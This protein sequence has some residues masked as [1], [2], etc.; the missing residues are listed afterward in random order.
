MLRSA[1][2]SRGRNKRLEY[3]FFTMLSIHRDSLDLLFPLSC[4]TINYPYGNPSS[5]PSYDSYMLQEGDNSDKVSKVPKQMR[6]LKCAY[7]SIH[8]YSGIV[9]TGRQLIHTTYSTTYNITIILLYE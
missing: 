6:L 8:K 9:A 1:S 4:S 5:E 7:S 3:Q 2:T